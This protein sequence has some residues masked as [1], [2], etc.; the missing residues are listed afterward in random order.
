M[1]ALTQAIA[2]AAKAYGAEILTGAEVAKIIMQNGQATAVKLANGDEISAA[3][4]VSAAD[5][6]TTF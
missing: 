4:V 3:V 5:M 2:S 6:R 1:G